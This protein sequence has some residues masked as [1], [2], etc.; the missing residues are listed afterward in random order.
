MLSILAPFRGGE[1]AD[2]LRVRRVER[3][4][5]LGGGA[6]AALDRRIAGRVGDAQDELTLVNRHQQ[7][8]EHPRHALRI[9]AADQPA[10]FGLRQKADE[11]QTRRLAAGPVEGLGELRGRGRLPRGRGRM[12]SITVGR[13]AP[14]CRKEVPKAKSVAASEAGRAPAAGRAAAS[15]AA[16]ARRH[17][18]RTSRACRG[19][20]R[21]VAL[22]DPGA[23]RDRERAGALV[24]LL[25]ERPN[26]ACRCGR[27]PHRLGVRCPSPKIWVSAWAWLSPSFLPPKNSSSCSRYPI[28]PIRSPRMVLG[29]AP[30]CLSKRSPMAQSANDAP[31]VRLAEKVVKTYRV[32]DI[33]VE[34]LKGVSLNIPSHRFTMV[35]GRRVAVRP[36]S[37]ISSAASTRHH[38]QRRGRGPGDRRAPR[39]CGGGFPGAQYRLHL[40]GLQPGAGALGLRERRV[41]AAALGM[42]AAERRERTLAMLEAVGLRAGAPAPE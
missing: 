29:S 21:R 40:P 24:A 18:R 15:C 35:S 16:C 32:G 34:A 19:N 14:S 38:R 3:H 9:G 30:W 8:E 25:K 7:G 17:R 27:A 41:S 6:G 26:A 22:R 33:E 5:R 28:V 2:D 10:A 13:V 31:I 39:Q 12:T 4:R 20:W 23:G 37:S 11:R 36:R 42:P 1:G